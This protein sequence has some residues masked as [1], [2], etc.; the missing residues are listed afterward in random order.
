MFDYEKL[1]VY[2]IAL[3]FVISTIEIWDC[4]P[5]GSGEL[6]NQLK[7]ASFSFVL[8]IAEGAGETKQADK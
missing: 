3:E 8:N 6:V 5:R 7:R 2:R 4:L 1:D